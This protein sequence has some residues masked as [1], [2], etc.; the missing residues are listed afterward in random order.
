MENKAIDALIRGM[1]KG[2]H[3]GVQER[4]DAQVEQGLEQPTKLVPFDMLTVTNLSFAKKGGSPES[5][6]I[7]V[8]DIN[9]LRESMRYAIVELNRI[10]LD[11]TPLPTAEIEPSP[12]GKE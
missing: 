8:L 4:I 3:I 9:Q 2:A 11:I 12:R 1:F 5:E 7:A 10:G 6:F